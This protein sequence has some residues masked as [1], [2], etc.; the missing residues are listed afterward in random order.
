MLR[1]T[2]PRISWKV[3]DGRNVKNQLVVPIIMVRKLRTRGI[4]MCGICHAF[5]I[6]VYSNEDS[7]D[8][9]S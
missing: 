4:M 6:I 8:K 3:G 5:L 1:V 9:S 2:T 7:E